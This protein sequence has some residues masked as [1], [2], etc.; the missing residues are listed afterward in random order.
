MPE[1]TS[2]ILSSVVSAKF[3]CPQLGMHHKPCSEHCASYDRHDPVDRGISAPAGFSMPCITLNA[4]HGN[5]RGPTKP[6]QPDGHQ[7]GAYDCM[8]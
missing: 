7:R 3:F 5:I 1:N 2:R 8:G 6:E 4:R